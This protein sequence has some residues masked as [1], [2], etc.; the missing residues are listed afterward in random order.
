M[1]TFSI[2]G[3]ELAQIVEKLVKSPTIDKL[4]DLA[5]KFVKGSGVATPHVLMT[6]LSNEDLVCSTCS[7]SNWRIL[8]TFWRPLESAKDLDDE[9][10]FLE[11][12]Q[13]APLPA[14]ASVLGPATS[15]PE[16]RP[17]NQLGREKNSLP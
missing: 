14:S 8:E 10:D 5:R 2:S 1:K 4:C 7:A 13:L 3:P 16:A 9:L 6:A 15:S 17:R 11:D 12:E